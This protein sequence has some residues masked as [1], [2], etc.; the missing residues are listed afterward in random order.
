MKHKLPK[1]FYLT[2]SRDFTFLNTFLFG[3]EMIRSIDK[4]IGT[5]YEQ[6]FYTHSKG[7]IDFYRSQADETRFTSFIGKKCLN[8]ADYLHTICSTLHSLTDEITD[9]LKTNPKIDTGNLD[10]YLAFQAKHLAYHLAVYWGG[11]YVGALPESLENKDALKLLFE[12]RAYNEHILPDMEKWVLSQSY[13]ALLTKDELIDY[14]KTGNK[15]DDKELEDREQFALVYIDE[16]DIRVFSG[17]AA[18]KTFSIIE[19]D[20]DLSGAGHF[21]GTLKGVGVSKGVYRG[22]VQNIHLPEEF[23]NI[24]PGVVVVAGQTRPHYNHFIQ[25]AGAI[26]VDEGAMLGHA[27]ILARESNLPTIIGTKFGTKVLKDGDMVEVDADNGTVK[28]I[29]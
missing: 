29:K 19:S 13:V 23:I 27:A 4:Y 7:Q 17:D 5:H 16:N 14:V 2:F 20:L 21:D 10:T 18:K 22:I 11:D 15:P 3:I 8:D 26:V 28:I 9:F 6:C 25:R 1:D 24:K 12:A